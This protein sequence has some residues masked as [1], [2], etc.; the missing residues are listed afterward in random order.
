M[1]SKQYICKIDNQY[2]RSIELNFD[3]RQARINNVA[4]RPVYA[5]RT[6]FTPDEKKS[7]LPTGRR[8][9]AKAF[10][11]YFKNYSL[12]YSL[13]SFT[14]WLYLSSA[15]FAAFANSS[16]ARSGKN[17]ASELYRTSP[18]MKSI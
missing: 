14:R 16:S 18:L 8:L 1:I 3:T 5:K 12:S 2:L 7:R 11:L 17:R 9:F 15:V 4:T 10:A 13:E 6:F